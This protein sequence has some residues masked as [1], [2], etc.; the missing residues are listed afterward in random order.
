[1]RTVKHQGFINI[2]MTQEEANLLATQIVQ[3]VNELPTQDTPLGKLMSLGTV[4]IAATIEPEI[5]APRGIETLKEVQLLCEGNV[6]K[7]AFATWEVAIRDKQ[8]RLATLQK[9]PVHKFLNKNHVTVQAI[10]FQASNE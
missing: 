4:E 9:S 8:N 7:V 10:P 2:R 1:M 5:I 3:S 6:P